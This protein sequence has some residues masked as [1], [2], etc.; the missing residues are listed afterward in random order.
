M[1]SLYILQ[2]SVTQPTYLS[3]PMNLIEDDLAGKLSIYIKCLQ[4]VN[5]IFM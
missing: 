4:L 5:D 3:E 2:T 1:Q